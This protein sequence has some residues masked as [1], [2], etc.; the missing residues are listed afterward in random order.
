DWEKQ[1]PFLSTKWNGSYTL[2]EPLLALDTIYNGAISPSGNQIICS[3]KKANKQEIILFKRANNWSKPVN[4]TQTSN[5]QG[6]YFYW[7]NEEELYFYIP[8]NNGDIVKGRLQGN[9]L[10]I[11]NRLASLNTPNGTEFS[12][13]LN[14]QNTMIIFTRYLEDDHTEQGF[15][16]SFQLNQ[17]DNDKWSKPQRLTSLPYG[18]NPYITKD[19]KQFLY[20]DGQDIISVPTKVLYLEIEQLKKIAKRK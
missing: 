15:F 16:V 12:T 5:I 8:E 10:F 7:Q 1:L 13:W 19:S 14:E 20:T 9:R 3:V 2:A 4:L 6:G 18:W 17:S 11:T